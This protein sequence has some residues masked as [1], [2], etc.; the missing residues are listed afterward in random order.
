MVWLLGAVC[1]MMVHGLC[2]TTNTEETNKQ[3][4]GRIGIHRLWD[5]L[6]PLGSQGS[7]KHLNFYTI[8]V[9]KKIRRIRVRHPKNI[10]EFYY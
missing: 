8:P 7:V 4:S 5:R 3:D 2:M 6:G 1:V 10:V 9:V